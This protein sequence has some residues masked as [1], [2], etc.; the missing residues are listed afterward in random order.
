VT[1][2]GRRRPQ[3]WWDCP[4]CPYR[5]ALD[6]PG[7]SEDAIAGHQNAHRLADAGKMPKVKPGLLRDIPRGSGR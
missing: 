1:A 2:D 5:I 4:R 3:R 7:G 6:H